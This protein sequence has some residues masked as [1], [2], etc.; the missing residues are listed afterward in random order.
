MRT[1]LA[2]LLEHRRK[3]LR[4]SQQEL[5]EL[6]GIT[7]RGYRAMLSGNPRLDTLERVCVVLGLAV[8]LEVPRPGAA[9]TRAGGS[10]GPPPRNGEEDAQS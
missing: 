7:A 10:A 2:H 8:T 4:L 5:A 9:A 1:D 6:A 3:V